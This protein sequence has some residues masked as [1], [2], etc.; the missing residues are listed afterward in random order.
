MAGS[1]SSAAVTAAAPPS[2]C[3]QRATIRVESWSETPQ[4][5]PAPAKIARPTAAARPGPD[6]AR[7]QRRGHRGQRH[8]QVEGDQHPGDA[9]DAGVELAVDLRQRQD[10]DRGVGQDEADGE[11]QRRDARSGGLGRSVAQLLRVLVAVGV[12]ACRA[13]LRRRRGFPG[14]DVARRSGRCR[15]TCRRCPG[16]RCR[17][18][19]R[20]PRRRRS[21]RAVRAGRK[22]P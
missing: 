16:R 20:R 8:H 10:D 3:T 1:S 19:A 21:G 9:G 12:A 17:R 7:Q 2:A 13:P 15:P 22:V 4:A 14:R 6:P 18:R 11:R 5:R